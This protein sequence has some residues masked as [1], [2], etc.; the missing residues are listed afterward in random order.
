MNY[1][2]ITENPPEKQE[3]AIPNKKKRDCVAAYW[4]IQILVW[5]T[6][7][8]SIVLYIYCNKNFTLIIIF[9]ML[10]LAY[11]LSNFF[12][13]FGDYLRNKNSER[14]IYEKMGKL[15]QTPPEITFEC[16]CYHDSNEENNEAKPDGSNAHVLRDSITTYK[17]SYK[18]SYY[19]ARDVSGLFNLNL[20]KSN[21]HKKYYIQL[22]LK[23]EINL[24]DAITHYDY[25][26]E[27]SEFC[28][29]N[30][31]RDVFFRFKETK[32]IPGIEIYNLIQIS[33]KEL[34]MINLFW[35]SFFTILTF[36]EFY[37]LYVDS[38]CIYQIFT[39]KKLVSTRY[40]LNQPEYQESIP[41]LDLISQQYQYEEDYYNYKNENYDLKIPTDEELEKAEQYQDKIQNY[42]ISINK[43]Q[44]QQDIIVDKPEYSNCIQNEPPAEISTINNSAS[45]GQDPISGT[46]APPP[47]YEQ[48]N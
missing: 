17:E 23:E 34:F 38:C 37:K 48:E 8:S 2:P 46:G 32:K 22:E 25:E 36:A 41:K 1:T 10:Y 27:K 20:G 42:Q 11:L 44:F 24:A 45:I 15:F 3:Q 39:I 40:G 19:T 26:N 29:R 16:E 7:P 31:Y 13:P 18:L 14:G 35:F 12:S 43:G 9:C 4:I 5:C 21:L 33:S 28:K 6:L 30:R 47:N